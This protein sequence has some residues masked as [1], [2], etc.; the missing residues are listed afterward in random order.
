MSIHALVECLK[1]ETESIASEYKTDII[2]GKVI[3]IDPLKIS[4]DATKIV[5][6]DN[7][8]TLSA[9][10]T[11]QYITQAETTT[12]SSGGENS[13]THTIPAKTQLLWR[14]LR[15]NDVVNIVHSSDKQKYYI[16]G[17]QDFKIW[18]VGDDTAN[19]SIK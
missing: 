1:R 18:G 9:F 14:G 11:D 17:Y 12:N 6:S 8:L 3:S 19:N 13:H 15:V 5:L 2:W 10:C 7:F 16:L 4:L